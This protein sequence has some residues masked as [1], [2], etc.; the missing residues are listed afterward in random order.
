MTA[1]NC[2]VSIRPLRDPFN[3][4]IRYLLVFSLLDV[5]AIR[6]LC[7]SFQSSS[8]LFSCSCYLFRAINNLGVL[9]GHSASG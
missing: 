4:F 7:L 6:T 9:P 5:P 2:S 3:G 8:R 1:A